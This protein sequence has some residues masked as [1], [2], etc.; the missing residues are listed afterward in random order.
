[1]MKSDSVLLGSMSN[2][3]QRQE[4]G[5][6]L[7]PQQLTASLSAIAPNQPQTT[8]ANGSPPKQ[9]KNPVRTSSGPGSSPLA[10]SAEPSSEDRKDRELGRLRSYFRRFPDTWISAFDLTEVSGSECLNTRIDELGL[11]GIVIGHFVA[12]RWEDRWPIEKCYYCYWPDG[13]PVPGRRRRTRLPKN[14][15]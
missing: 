5:D 7:A 8:L 10:R 3:M 13:W 4:T 9:E 15:Q 2:R 11:E 1:M 14:R 12:C 6:H